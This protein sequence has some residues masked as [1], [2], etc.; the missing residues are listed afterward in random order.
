MSWDM[1]VRPEARLE[2]YAGINDGYTGSVPISHSIQ[3]F[4]RTV[5][6][7]G[8]AESKVGQTDVVN[9]LTRGIQR[10]THPSTIGGREV[11]YRRDTKP[12]SLVIFDGTHEMLAEYC[13][14]RMRQIVEG[15]VMGGNSVSPHAHQ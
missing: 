10:N 2:I 1:R 6:H 7:Y 4:N 11:V 5:E 3:F 9:L 12:A 13:F 14:D 8:Y 15:D